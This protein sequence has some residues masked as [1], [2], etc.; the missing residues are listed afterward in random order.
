MPNPQ[1]AA[2]IHATRHAPGGPDALTGYEIAGA[3]AAEATARAAAITAEATARAAADAALNAN[4]A[5]N[6]ASITTKTLAD[7]AAVA[8]ASGA[9]VAGRHNPVD[10]TAGNLTMTL[11]DATAPGRVTVVEKTDASAN[12]VTITGNIRGS[13]GSVVLVWQRE[14][15]EL[16]SKA[17][18]SWWPIAGHKTKTSLDA[19]YA[20]LGAFTKTDTLEGNLDWINNS[21]SGYLAHFR[22]GSLSAAGTAMIGI[23]TDQGSAHGI[24]I[25]HKNAGNGLIM[26]VQPSAGAG[27]VINARSASTPIATNM[28]AGSGAI[29]VQIGTGA[30]YADGATTIG[31]TT[32]TSATATFVVGDVG[33]VLGQLTSRSTTDPIGCIPAGTTIAAYISPTQVT[34]SQSSAFTGSAIMFTVGGRVMA[35]TQALLTVLSEVAAPLF[36]VTK[37]GL[38]I[39]GGDAA[40]VPLKV[41]GTAGQTA[42]V[43]AAFISGNATPVLSIGASGAMSAPFC[44]SMSNAGVLGGD[45][46]TVSTYSSHA[47]IKAARVGAVT[48]DNF[49]AMGGGSTALSRFNKDGYFMTAKNA[50]PADADV[51]TGELALWFDSTNG[52]SKLMI[53]AKQADGTVKTAS[54]ALA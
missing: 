39:A 42:N 6:T 48:G 16:L 31:S 23:G 11:A 26:G 19:A 12:T 43:L 50:A 40:Q 34:M 18:G 36:T 27:L 14:A 20:P 54:V 15:I 28:Q 10:A 13:A 30:S 21:T 45:P 9:L 49:W 25:S 41:T 24:L 33:A 8:S 22:A 37:G 2:A 53:K 7:V 47:S 17:D 35:S 51:N 1:A 46:L 52:A 32:F 44:A 38:T 3:A 29:T 4:V 5:A